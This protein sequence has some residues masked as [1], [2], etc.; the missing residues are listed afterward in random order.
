MADAVK[1]TTLK[2]ISLGYAAVGNSLL[3][4]PATYTNCMGVLKGFQVAQDAYDETNVEAEFFDSPFDILYTGKPIKFTFDLVNYALSEL[5]PLFG[6]TYTAA[7]AT[8][9]ETYEGATSAYTSEWEWHLS[10]QKGNRGLVLYKGKTVG[11]VKKEATGAL[12]YSVT[13]TSLIYNDGTNDHMYKIIG[14]AKTGA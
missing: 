2:P 4:T 1:K 13:I 11:L 3:A 6:G 8:A 5:P 7:T 14:E 10:F 9:D 12:G